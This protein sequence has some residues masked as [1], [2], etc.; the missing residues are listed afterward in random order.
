MHDKEIR[1]PV[2][3]AGA[4]HRWCKPPTSLERLTPDEH[5]SQGSNSA[6]KNAPGLVGRKPNCRYEAGR[7]E[8]T[9]E[10]PIRHR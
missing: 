2:S 9:S 7:A 5:Q 10:Q 6:T 3:V 4:L 1:T 8:I